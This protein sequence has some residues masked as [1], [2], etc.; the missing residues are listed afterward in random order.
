MEGDTENLSQPFVA[1]AHRV[2]QEGVTNALRYASG[3]AVRVL[4]RGDSEAMI[5]EVANDAAERSGALAGHSTG[6]GLRGLRER[7]AG[8]GGTLQAGP[9]ADGGWTLAARLPR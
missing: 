9:R 4:V 8:L 3:A 7:A 1:F 5:V 6:N 2:A